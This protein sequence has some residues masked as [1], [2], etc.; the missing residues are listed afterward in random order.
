ME[1]ENKEIS[2]NNSQNITAEPE[3]A[4]DDRKESEDS[5]QR[6]ERKRYPAKCSECG[7]DCEVPFEP[8]EGKPV[9]CNE[10]FRKSRRNNNNNRFKKRFYD[11]TCSKCSSRCQ[12]PFRPNGKKPILCRDCFQKEKQ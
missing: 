4:M 8:V 7:A 10:C 3:T 12:V 1:E 11:A 5:G 9:K 6:E 2:Q